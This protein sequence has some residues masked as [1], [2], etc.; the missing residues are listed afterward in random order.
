MLGQFSVAKIRQFSRR[1]PERPA[2]RSSGRGCPPG[3]RRKRATMAELDLLSRLL[4]RDGLMLVIDSL[5]GCRCIAGRRAATIW[6]IVSVNCASACRARRR[7][8]TGST[9]TRPAVSCS[10]GIARRWSVSAICSR[11][12]G[13]KRPIG[14]SSR[15][16]PRTTAARSTWRWAGSTRRG[17]GGCGSIRW[18]SPPEPVGASLGRGV[19]AERRELALA[20]TEA[21]HRPHPSI[22]RAH[23]GDGLAYFGR[24]DL[25]N[26]PQGGARRR[27][28][29]TRAA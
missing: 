23:A 18:G 1:L 6:R 28:I 4:H 3:G 29:S 5:L 20:G 12:A 14:R 19:D 16:R 13:F 2:A 7:W 9:R 24:S 21:P 25:R 8:P 11:A 27:C 26:G 10:D 15:A 17:A 22:A